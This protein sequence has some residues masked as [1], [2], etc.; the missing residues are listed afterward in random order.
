M[1]AA[2]LFV[3]L[4]LLALGAWWSNE[5]SGL[6]ALA[7][8]GSSG[9]STVLAVVSLLVGFR[10]PLGQAMLVAFVTLLTLNWLAVGANLQRLPAVVDIAPAGDDPVTEPA[11]A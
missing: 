2:I 1:F 9:I 6:A 4:T 11:P 5:W 7:V 3:S 8:V 10:G